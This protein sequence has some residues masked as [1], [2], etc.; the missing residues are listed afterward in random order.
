MAHKLYKVTETKTDWVIKITKSEFFD[1][2]G[3]KCTARVSGNG[4]III[5]GEA[6]SEEE[7]S[8]EE[9]I[10][11]VDSDEFTFI[12]PL[13]AGSEE[14]TPIMDK[15]GNVTSIDVGCTSINKADALKLMKTLKW[16][17]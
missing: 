1:N 7:F 4:V 3:I 14:V 10:D 17:K 12:E 8:P 13:F 16:I 9:F 2:E 5:K 11:M 6:S 15:S